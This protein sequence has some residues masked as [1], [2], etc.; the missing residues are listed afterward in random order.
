MLVLDKV[1]ALLVDLDDTLYE[2][3][4][5]VRSGFRAVAE[6][7]GQENATSADEIFYQLEYQFAREGRRGV[8]DRTMAYLGLQKPSMKE[9]VEAYRHHAPQIDLYP[10]VNQAL[11]RL[12]QQYRV[13][14]VTDG[15]GTMQRRKVEAL[16]LRDE[17]RQIVYCWDLGAPKPDPAGYQK[18]L[19]SLEAEPHEALVIGDDPYHDM[20]AA[21]R[22][23]ILACRTRTGRFATIPTPPA[24]PAI[25]EVPSFVS[26]SETLLLRRT[27]GSAR[28]GV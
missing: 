21:A 23:G 16:G 18:A 1:K 15:L 17:V 2:E 27:V 12:A 6:I 24:A 10:G 9:L 8:F 13:A 11:S 28:D 14:I 3:G 25:M 4:R 22:A 19:S 5:Y 26:L 7:L 20:P